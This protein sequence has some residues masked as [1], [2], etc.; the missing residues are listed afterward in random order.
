MKYR[1]S[2]VFS[3]ERPLSR[4]EGTDQWLRHTPTTDERRLLD[5]IYALCKE[6]IRP[7]SWIESQLEE[8]PNE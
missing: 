8:L 5:G 1:L 7:N 6:Y 3:T 4:D 2:I